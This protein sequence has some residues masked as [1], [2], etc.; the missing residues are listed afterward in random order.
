MANC[1]RYKSAIHCLTYNHSQFIEKAMNGFCEQ[2][3]Q[4]PFICILIDDASTDDS[5]KIILKYL[6]D[7]FEIDNNEIYNRESTDDYDLYFSRHKTNNNCYFAFYLLKY[8]YYSINK[9]K[10][11]LFTRWDDKVD[12]IAICEGD[13]Y[14]IDSAKLQKQCV[15]LENHS[16]YSMVCNRTVLFSQKEG[17]FVG[18]NYCYLRS[19]DITVKDM[20]YRTGL[21][22]ST[23][24]IVYRREVCENKP[25]YWRFCA[26]GDYPLQIACVM[27]GKC[28]Y[29]NEAMSVYRINNP[30]SWM[31]NQN[32]S[33]GGCD[34]KRKIVIE[35]R[36]RMFKGF[37]LDYPQYNKLL[38]NKIADEINRNIPGRDSGISS[39]YKHLLLFSDEI[40][41]YSLRWKLDL[42][43]RKSRIPYVR[44]LYTRLFMRSYCHK[45]LHYR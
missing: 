31:G 17:R 9:S 33:G 12:Y 39:V 43:F 16:N 28:W 34:P 21:F 44:G 32:W 20:I 45:V 14:W 7:F 18:E 27:K 25:D 11:D 41:K 29:M 6:N 22:V 35:S 8:N 38:N 5:Q 19:R 13:D 26:V 40:K 23:C 10:I 15:F 42:F 4:F 36:I 2:K 37:A 1:V 24:S 30:S 3:T